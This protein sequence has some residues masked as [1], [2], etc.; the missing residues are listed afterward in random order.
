[1]IRHSWLI[2]TVLIG[3]AALGGCRAR[4]GTELGRRGDEIVVCGRYF[5]TGAPVVLWMD[6]GGYDAYRTDKRFVPWERAPWQPPQAG[7][8]ADGPS[9][10]DRYGIRFAS[11][12]GR[13][14]CPL[15]AEEFERIRGGGWELPTLQRCVDQFVLHYD[16]CGTSR[17]C[18]RVLH[19]MRGLSVHFM[20]DIDGTIYQTLD[21]KERAWHATTS[22]DRSVG[23]EIANMGAY[24]EKDTDLLALWYEPDPPTWADLR[25]GSNG[26]RPPQTYITVPERLGDGGVRTPGF[27]GEPV[28]GWPVL[29]FIQGRELRQYDLT[30]QQYDSLV[31]L[32]ATLCSVFPNLPCD[33]P[34]DERGD[35]ITS[36]LP[37][38]ELA[39][40]RGLIGHYH[41][42]S[43]KTDPG[44]ALQ[45]DY[46]VRSARSQIG[47]AP[48]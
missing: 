41:I 37:D 3:A 38:E 10:P 29:G 24:G 48:R 36:K 14:E 1:M 47:P 42:Q 13:P 19:D 18:F 27:V 31:K 28:G 45:W 11:Q 44:P 26:A 34:R 39:A 7:Q 12:L 33:Y 35:L 9:S 6:P 21:L 46:L 32:T 25:A 20:L 8:R 40:F 16:V 43:N 4:P 30:P 17:Q 23:I 2:L 5:H 22:N 15:S